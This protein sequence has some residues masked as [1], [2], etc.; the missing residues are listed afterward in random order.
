MIAFES[1]D[2]NYLEKSWVWLNDPEIK[3]LTMTPDFT[4][5][6]QRKWFDGLSENKSYKIWGVSY[7]EAPIGVFGIKSINHI[8]GEG[9]YWGYIGEKEYWGKGLGKKIM[10]EVLQKAKFELKLSNIYLKVS[11]QNKVAISLYKKLNFI[12]TDMIDNELIIM[13]I[14]L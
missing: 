14:A 10:S 7:D 12:E 2:E 8:K 6:Q 3:K 11:V 13:T 5:S 9:E 1:Y 4:I